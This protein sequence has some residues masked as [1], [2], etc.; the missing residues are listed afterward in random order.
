MDQAIGQ[1]R[2]ALTSKIHAIVDA[3]G[4][5][6]TLSLTPGQRADITEAKLLLNEIDPKAFIA[7]KTYDGDPL[8]KEKRNR[9]VFRQTETI[10]RH[11][12]TLQQAENQISSRQFTS[13][14]Q[15]SGLTD[16]TPYQQQMKKALAGNADRQHMI[17]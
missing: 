2:V 15:F 9:T 16:D 11:R 17:F 1:S 5:T 13:S 3:A 10:Q 8:I 7:D 12:N 6:V 4:K 14:T